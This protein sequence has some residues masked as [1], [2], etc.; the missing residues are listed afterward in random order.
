ML[1]AFVAR[2]SEALADGH[3]AG[4]EALLQTEDD[5]LWDWLQGRGR[6]EDSEIGEIIE[7]IRRGA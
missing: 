2:E 5:Q 1:A 7:A 4:F 6:P 3:W